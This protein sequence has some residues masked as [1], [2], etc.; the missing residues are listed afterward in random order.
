MFTTIAGSLQMSIKWVGTASLVALFGLFVILPSGLVCGPGYELLAAFSLGAVVSYFLFAAT[1]HHEASLPIAEDHRAVAGELKQALHQRSKAK[2]KK[3]VRS[4]LLAIAVWVPYVVVLLSLG[5]TG[6]WW[7]LAIVF[8][9]ISIILVLD[10][11][12]TVI[13]D[14]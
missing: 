4:A 5:W 6:W 13:L 9:L 10:L 3:A 8:A 12:G 7:T 2:R 1:E 11:A 14:A